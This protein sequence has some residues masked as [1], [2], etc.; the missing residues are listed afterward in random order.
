MRPGLR[1][2]VVDASLALG[3]LYLAVWIYEVGNFLAFYVS[4][5]NPSLTTAG[6][7]PVG[8][9][10]M[11]SGTSQLALVKPLQVLFSASMAAAVYWF[12]RGRGMVFSQMAAVSMVGIFLAS[13]YWEALSVA[14][15]IPIGVHVAIFTSLALGLQY[16]LV[17]ASRLV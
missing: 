3:L 15:F 6:V 14:S 16:G 1:R 7:L 10:A 13:F 4:G 5:F 17:K 12:L 2:A 9:S 11:V 8:V